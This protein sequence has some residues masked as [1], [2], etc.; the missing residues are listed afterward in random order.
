MLNEVVLVTYVR[1]KRRI[2]ILYD[3]AQ[4]NGTNSKH[5][6]ECT[7]LYDILFMSVSYTSVRTLS[8]SELEVT[9]EKFNIVNG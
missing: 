3:I 4:N 8:S 1:S 9:E 5:I 2:N 6:I 7:G